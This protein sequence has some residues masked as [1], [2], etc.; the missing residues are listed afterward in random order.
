MQ[1]IQSKLIVELRPCENLMA[2]GMLINMLKV[3]AFGPW[4]AASWM[5]AMEA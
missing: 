3:W 2:A 5:L 4:M 1:N